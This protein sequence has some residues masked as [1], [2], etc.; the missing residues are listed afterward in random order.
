MKEELDAI[1]EL[2]RRGGGPP[3]E[4]EEEESHKENRGPPATET[5]AAEASTDDPGHWVKPEGESAA[6]DSEAVAPEDV[7]AAT[8][9]AE[10][11]EVG[12]EEAAGQQTGKK[13]VSF[14]SLIFAFP[15]FKRNSGVKAEVCSRKTQ[16]FLQSS[17]FFDIWKIWRDVK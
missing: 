12:G 13:H 1:D 8:D 5:S 14:V 3:V 16:T 4:E 15:C 10:P 17:V 11:M 7:A 2:Y 9:A 6:T